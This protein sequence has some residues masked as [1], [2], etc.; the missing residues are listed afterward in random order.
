MRI[1]LPGSLFISFQA[2]SYFPQGELQVKVGKQMP[3][4]TSQPPTASPDGTLREGHCKLCR[5]LAR[6]GGTRRGR[7]SGVGLRRGVRFHGG[8]HLSRGRR[9]CRG[10][11]TA[12]NMWGGISQGD[13][14]CSHLILKARLIY[15]NIYIYIIILYTIYPDFAEHPLPIDP[16]GSSRSVCKNEC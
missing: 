7:A 5:G 10:N 6:D 8:W 13:S 11:K 1:V 4:T 12:R 2:P 14:A 16:R 15:C 9:T 3:K